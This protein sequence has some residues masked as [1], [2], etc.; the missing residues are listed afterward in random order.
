MTRNENLNVEV[1]GN[2]KRQTPTLTVRV[3]PDLLDLVDKAVEAS[4]NQYQTRTDLVRDAVEFY[5][6]HVS[7][8]GL[9]RTKVEE[10][11]ESNK[12]DSEHE[13]NVEEALELVKELT[14]TDIETIEEFASEANEKALP[15]SVWADDRIQ[16]AMRKILRD[17]IYPTGFWDGIRRF[18]KRKS[19]ECVEVLRKQLTI[20]RSVAKQLVEDPDFSG[21]EYEEWS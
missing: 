7:E 10:P 6:R 2:E 14:D 13:A 16:T 1:E 12:D 8:G 4:D 20:P 21:R 11:E 18:R 3:T 17:Q 15:K 19:R 5:S 9:N